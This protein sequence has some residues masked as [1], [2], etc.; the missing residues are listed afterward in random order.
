MS[1]EVTIVCDGSCSQL[2]DAGPT[3]AAVRAALR[4]DRPAGRYGVAGGRD[5][6][7]DCWREAA[8]RVAGGRTP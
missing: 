7:P 3:A 5:F 6:C 8:E 1:V 2:L 4:R